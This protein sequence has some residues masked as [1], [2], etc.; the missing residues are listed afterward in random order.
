MA[1]KNI[2]MSNTY[3]DE[4]H[5]CLAY[6]RDPCDYSS[7]PYWKETTFSLPAHIKIYREREWLELSEI[8][9]NAF[10]KVDIFF[11]TKHNLDQIKAPTLPAEYVFRTFDS[12]REEDFESALEIIH[13]S[14]PNMKVT[15]DKLRGSLKNG[16]YDGDLWVFIDKV[17]SEKKQVVAFGLA[18]LDSS[19]QEGILEWIQVLPEYRRKGLGEALVNELLTRMKGKAKFATVS[20]DWNNSYQPVKL[21]EKCGFEGNRLWYIAYGK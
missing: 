15:K 11:R 18:D 12:D 16:V 4:V 6:V 1:D 5:N 19:M 10:E 9:K 7:L 3:C 13:L 20:G 2:I 21:Y 14:Y 17:G 8:E